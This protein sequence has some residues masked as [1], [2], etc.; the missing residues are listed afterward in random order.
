MENIV[1]R[2]NCGLFF[3]R[4]CDLKVLLIWIFDVIRNEFVY[5]FNKFFYFVW[6]DFNYNLFVDI[7]GCYV[8]IMGEFW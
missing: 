2:F 1:Y 4:F 8:D 3:D 5:L 6:Q 7:G